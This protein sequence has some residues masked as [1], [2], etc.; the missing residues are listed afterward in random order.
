MI[1]AAEPGTIHFETAF[2]VF[3]VAPTG[4]APKGSADIIS[5]RPVKK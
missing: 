2:A 1:V 3:D 4:L 5:T